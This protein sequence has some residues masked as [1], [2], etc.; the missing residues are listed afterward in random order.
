[1]CVSSSPYSSTRDAEPVLTSEPVFAVLKNAIVHLA[2]SVFVHAYPH[3]SPTFFSTLLALLRTYPPSLAV[4]SSSTGAA[5]LNPQ[6]TDLFLR[7]LHE[8]SLEIS[9]AQLRLNK[10]TSR[11]QKDTELRD[12]VRERDAAGIAEAVWS[13]IGE[14]LEGVD[15]PDQELKV[16]LKGKT[17]RE[18]AEM[19]VRVAGDYVCASPLPPLL[20]A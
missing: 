16:G 6:T 9:D 14:A 19:A 5:P 7:I 20:H 10:P 8:V 11:L 3:V 17:A 4:P 2:A 1:M 12:A 18:V 15:A 13:V